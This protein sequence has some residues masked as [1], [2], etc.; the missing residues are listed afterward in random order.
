MRLALSDWILGTHPGCCGPTGGDGPVQMELYLQAGLS[1]PTGGAIF[2]HT[3]EPGWE[4]QG[5]GRTLFFNPAQEAAWVIDLSLNNIH[6]QGQHPEFLVGLNHIL[7]PLSTNPA[8]PNSP[9][10]GIVNFVPGK[11]R[12]QL[13]NPGHGALMPDQLVVP[14]LPIANLNRTFANASLGREWYLI[15]SGAKCHGGCDHDCSEVTWRIGCDGGGRWG[16]AKLELHS[17]EAP[18]NDPVTGRPHI[19]STRHRTDVI[20]GAFVGVHSDVEIPC[21]CCI[22]QAGVR[23]E[24]DYTFMNILQDQNNAD[25]QELNLLFTAGVRF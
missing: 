3:L 16:S 9:N 23:V 24:W 15:G 19:L 20:E 7:V 13:A 11:H 4:I 8:N 25:F 12:V 2:G 5:G 21:G 6:N 10:F 17:V 1:F 14:G 22:F 18:P